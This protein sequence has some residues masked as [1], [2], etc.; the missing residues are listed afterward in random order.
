L[1]D[2][3]D[4]C[5]EYCSRNEFK[6]VAVVSDNVSGTVP[7]NERSGGKRLWQMIEDRTVEVVVLFKRDRTG[8]DDLGLEYVMLKNL[9]YKNGLELHYVLTWTL[10]I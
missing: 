7:I 2:Q 9:V 4:A 3:E 1:Q 10:S 5:R 6:V 8:R